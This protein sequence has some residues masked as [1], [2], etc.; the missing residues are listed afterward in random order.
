MLHSH[1]HYQLSTTSRR[2]AQ[3]SVQDIG[4][5]QDFGPGLYLSIFKGTDA[6]FYL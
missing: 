1:S 5:D 4:K 6:L 3:K 2:Y